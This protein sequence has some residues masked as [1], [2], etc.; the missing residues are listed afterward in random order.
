VEF[1]TSTLIAEAVRELRKMERIEP[2]KV[3]IVAGR[4]EV[5]K[6]GVTAKATSVAEERAN[7][8][9]RSS[10]PDV[11]A[12]LQNATELT[13]STLVR[14]LKESGR[15]ASYSPIPSDSW[16]Q[17]PLSYGGCSTV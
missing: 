8:R 5:A 10:L 2:P 3:R 7:L 6:G 12:Y 4:M 16:T 11:L 14:I 9:G 15:L 13:R 17:P 1:E